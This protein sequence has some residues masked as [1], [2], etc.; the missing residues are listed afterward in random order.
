MLYM[1]EYMVVYKDSYSVCCVC[2][3]SHLFNCYLLVELF[4]CFNHSL[5]HCDIYIS[6]YIYIYLY[7]YIYTYICT[8]VY[9]FIERLLL[10]RKKSKIGKMPT[11][12]GS[13]ITMLSI[14]KKLQLFVKKNRKWEE[15]SKFK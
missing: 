1:L 6:I 4:C 2:V 3:V 10:K 12:P 7:I 8:H 11:N 13:V 14:M 5:H 9:R 15:K